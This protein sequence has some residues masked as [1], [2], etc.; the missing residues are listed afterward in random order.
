MMKLNILAALRNHRQWYSY[1]LNNVE[2]S[3][4]VHGKYFSLTAISVV[5]LGSNSYAFAFMLLILPSLVAWKCTNSIE[6]CLVERS[7][8][9]PKRFV[10]KAY[11]LLVI[12]M[13]L[14]LTK[15]L[16]DY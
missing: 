4:F 1:N 9:F 13:L 7:I 15:L 10:L 12:F 16:G 5:L 8:R 2:R 3:L 14:G 6:E 11:I